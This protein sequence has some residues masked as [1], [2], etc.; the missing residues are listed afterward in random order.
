MQTPRNI[1]T[2]YADEHQEPKVCIEL[3]LIEVLQ[4]II[5]DWL[6]SPG[7]IIEYLWN[8]Y[9]IHFITPIVFDLWINFIWTFQESP[10]LF[11][12]KQIML[13]IKNRKESK[14]K[15]KNNKMRVCL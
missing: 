9:S 1:N 7:L 13:N 15:I 2:T 11:S 5:C 10:Q 14:S 12:N 4:S 8:V 6:Y 3:C